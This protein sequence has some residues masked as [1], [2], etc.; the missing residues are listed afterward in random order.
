MKR[1]EI[2]KIMENGLLF[3]EKEMNFSFALICQMDT[4]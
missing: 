2:N 4:Q 1:S 3:I